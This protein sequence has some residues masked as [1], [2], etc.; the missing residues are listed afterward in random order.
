[1][2]R[3]IKLLALD[4]D[5]TVLRS[6][7][8]LSDK[9]KSA[10]ESA[11]YSGITIAAA[12]GRP[13]SSM[14]KEILDMPEFEYYIAS[15]GAA[16]YDKNGKKLRSVTLKEKDV[17]KILKLT[18]D[19][20]LIWEAF[21]EGETCTDIRYY[22]D[23]MSYGCSA[24]YVDY[25]R[26]SRGIS[27]DMRG[28]I[29]KNRN[30]LD[31]IEFVSTDAELRKTIWNMIE[32]SVPDVY[33]TSSSTHFVEIMD[34]QATKANALRFIC[35]MLN[36]SLENTAAAGNADNDVDMIIEA[37]LGIAVKNA[38]DKCKSHADL[39]VSSND[40]DGIAELIDII[41]K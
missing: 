9:V 8:T 30:R 25:V 16:I 29:Y 14:P 23:P 21:I 22:N 35:D 40:D 1:M 5:G 4:L 10:I 34:G 39:I 37:G 18:E 15:N 13:F 3:K 20:D 2:D 27:D 24:A 32:K 31:S 26:S 6:N 17:I 7:N 19:Y 38:C 11:N 12:S 36:V 41:L 28:Y 33:V